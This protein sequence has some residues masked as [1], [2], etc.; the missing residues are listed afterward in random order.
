M[1]VPHIIMH[2]ITVPQ[3]L[4]YNSTLLLPIEA[5]KRLFENTRTNS[6]GAVGFSYGQ[7][8]NTVPKEEPALL[9]SQPF[10]PEHPP[11]SSVDIGEEE[12]AFSAPEGLTVPEG[13]KVVG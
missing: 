1:T 6:Y 2:Y 7:P 8:Q 10:L 5:E 3:T 4:A 11:T 12:D 13:I 9:V